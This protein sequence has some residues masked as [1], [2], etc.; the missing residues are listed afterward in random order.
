MTLFS[1][2]QNNNLK[3]LILLYIKHY[4][5][6]KLY[7]FILI[8]F[9]S[10]SIFG[11]DPVK[12]LKATRLV[13]PIK[14]DGIID[15]LQWSQAETAKDFIQKEPVPG[16]PASFKSE[17]H[18]LYDDYAVYVG[19]RLWDEDS[20]KILKE[21][22]LRD[23]MGN[24]DNFSV[25]FDPFR[26]GLNGF[27]FVVTA[28]G[29]QLE[30]I[31]TNHE[32]D[33]NWNAVWESAV[34]Q[35]DKGWYVE[36]KIPVSAL[37][38]PSDAIQKWNIQFA[39]EI[40]RYR[41]LSYWSPIHPNIA[42]W[43][44]QSGQLTD[45][46]N[47]ETPVRLSLTPYTSVYLNTSYDPTLD[48]DRFNAE[49]A[50]SAGLDLKY[51]IND[52][53]TLDMTLIPDFGQVIS[54]N[55]VLNLSPYEVFYE[56]NRQFFTEGTELFN[57]E[58]IFYSR[59]I[60]SSPLKYY[61]V[62]NQLQE[63]ESI[64]K[65]PL[66]SRLYNA[67]KI[68]GRTSKGT[69]IG[70]FN[71]VTGQEYAVIES[72]DG[73][74]R[75]FQTNPIT[76]YNAIVIDQNLKNNS[77]FSLMNTNVS[78]RGADYDANVTGAFINLKT[79]DQ[80]FQ[81]SG[82]GML[83]QKYYESTTDR[84]F[85]YNVELGK[86]SGIW[87]YGIGQKVYSDKFDPNDMGFLLYPN[88]LNYYAK[89]AYN[90]YH[91]KNAHILNTVIAGEFNYKRLYNPEVYSGIELKLNQ[92][93]LLKSRLGLGWDAIISPVGNHDYFEPRT[94]DLS[95][96]LIIPGNVQVGGFISTDYRKTLALDM[97]AGYTYFDQKNRYAYSL[98]F[99]PRIRFNDRFS[100]FVSS[101]INY[102]RNDPGYTDK[103]LAGVQ[104]DNLTDK[105]IMFGI[106]NRQTV[107]NAISGKY[108]FNAVMGLNLRVRHYWDKVL[109]R[110][111][112][113]LTETGSIQ[114]IAY[115]GKNADNEAIFDRNVN[116][117]NVDLQ[118]NWRF[119]PGSDI[120]FVW[121]N[122]IYTSDKNYD[123]DWISNFGNLTKAYQD[124]NISLRVLYYL[125]Y[126]YLKS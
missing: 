76:N 56:E 91:P 5:L 33:S 67:T 126:L 102:Y 93:M 58:N 9:N 62:S 116:I 114:S 86:V 120:I 85:S 38:F 90:Q 101:E 115:S 61:E 7:L 113:K 98:D 69:G 45:I 28:S 73:T 46:I 96:F 82:Y 92:F 19:A 32:E 20:G 43:V 21:Y 88:N 65:N 8:I 117:F 70:F 48:Q 4:P 34:S 6:K 105:D 74:S 81:L 64:V 106:R 75:K 29:I 18:V 95:Q 57:K 49:T 111:F 109:Y 87:T 39:R 60:G 42:G 23:E 100:V 107:E 121:K 89:G 25:F 17:V 79:S 14:I 3:K 83:S 31:V 125:D 15:E 118:Y 78:R 50:Y 13:E 22:S 99:S 77:F 123:S 119:A 94:S 12:T 27:L 108:I 63:G 51:G 54:D 124:N 30:S 59:R 72:A 103:S 44:Q 11:T 80:R 47:I 97:N 40:R 41:E 71:A 66:T 24:A 104:I 36:M 112:G 55:Q 16:L 1:R 26:S 37:R 52:A 53:F 122:Q 84:G 10:I 68:T 110:H 2:K 35:D